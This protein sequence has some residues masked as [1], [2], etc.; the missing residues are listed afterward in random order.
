M[1]DDIKFPHELEQNVHPD[2]EIVAIHGNDLYLDAAVSNGRQLKFGVFLQN[3][4]RE[5]CRNCRDLATE[6][7]PGNVRR[8]RKS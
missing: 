7:G 6:E 8:M 2:I 3:L 4:E 5:N 1:R